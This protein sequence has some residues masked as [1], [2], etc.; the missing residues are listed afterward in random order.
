MRNPKSVIDIDYV[1]KLANL[2]LTSSEKKTF[3]KQLKD[4]LG[5]VSKLQKVDT[6]KVEPI[7]HITGLVNVLREDKTRPSIS[8]QEALANAPKTHNGFFEVDAIFEEE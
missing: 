8:Q 7:G 4:V 1:A 6:R 5:Y 2:P 3:E